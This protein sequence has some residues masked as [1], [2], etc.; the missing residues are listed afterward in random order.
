MQPLVVLEGRKANVALFLSGG[1]SNARRILEHHEKHGDASPINPVALVT[2]RLDDPACGAH[3]L[4][5]RFGLPVTGLDIRR[6]YR[7]HGCL[8][9]S[10][11]TEEGRKLRQRWTEALRAAL[12]GVPIDFA[13]FAG[14]ET[15]TNITGD[16]C[17]LNVHP[18][19]L[20]YLKDGGRHLVGLQTEPIERAV[21][22]GLTELRSSVIVATP[23][24]GAG[25][26]MDSGPLLG[27]SPPVDID[28]QG[29]T[30]EALRA[31]QR[32]RPPKRPCGGYGDVLEEIAK[33]NQDRLKEGGD[34]VVFPEV[35]FSVA[36]EQ[37]ALDADGCVYYRKSRADGFT[38]AEALVF[39]SAKK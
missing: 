4:S 39:G 20:T 19:D 12:S 10:L 34:W 25:G 35:V 13:V 7:E 5:R 36:R 23:Y 28:L 6:F 31:V 3:E 9:V 38:R 11:R 14:F 26:D 27:I 37:F 17:C 8:S 16:F 2:D 15:L 22:E 33:H 1:G 32:K 21:V 30:V 18:G 24:C 29:R